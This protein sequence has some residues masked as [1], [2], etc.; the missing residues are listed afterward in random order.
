[1]TLENAFDYRFG[2]DVISAVE[3]RPEGRTIGST[4]LVHGLGGSKNSE[5]HLAVAK[6]LY[7]MGIATLRFDFPGHGESGGT[8]EELT[9]SRGAEL[10]DEFAGLLAERFTEKPIALLGARLWWQLHS[11][12]TDQFKGSGTRIALSSLRLPSGTCT[13]T[14]PQRISTLGKGRN[15]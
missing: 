15:D 5:T 7:K 6:Q 12:F 14:R 3:I 4:L 9:I 13:T 11:G 10:V 8:T 1:M 2:E